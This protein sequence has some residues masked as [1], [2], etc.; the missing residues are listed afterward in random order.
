MKCPKCGGALSVVR[1]LKHASYGGTALRDAEATKALEVNQC[2]GC[3]GVWFDAGELDQYIDERLLLLDSINTKDR[4]KH[5]RQDASC[6]KCGVPMAHEVLAQYGTTIVDLC[7]QCKGVWVDG[8]EIDGIE[9]QT[10][11]AAEKWKLF[12]AGVK[13]RFAKRKERPEER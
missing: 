12:I 4:K 2:L 13:E 1:I 9:R 7:D 5:N 10:L 6:P 3:N 8:D 11:P